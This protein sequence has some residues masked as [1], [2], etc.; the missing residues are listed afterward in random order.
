MRYLAAAIALALYACGENVTD[1]AMSSANAESPTVTSAVN[2]NSSSN[3]S[4][5]VTSGSSTSSNNVGS[6]TT[7]S[8]SSNNSTSSCSTEVNGKRCEISCRLPQA[9][10]CRQSASASEPSC[11]CK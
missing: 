6:T 11:F 4:S 5:S 7:Q 10:Q 2:S 1:R 8:S 9:A 3:V